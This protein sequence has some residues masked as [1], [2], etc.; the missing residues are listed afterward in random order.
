[1]NGEG[2]ILFLEGMSR[3]WGKHFELFIAQNDIGM[4]LSD[5]TSIVLRYIPSIS[6]LLRD[7]YYF[8]GGMLNLLTGLFCI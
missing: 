5:V 1:M 8:Y 3:S 7:Y 4:C 2:Y 6:D